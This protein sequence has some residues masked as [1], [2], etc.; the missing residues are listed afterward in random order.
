MIGPDRYNIRVYGICLNAFGQVL[1][2]DERRNGVTMTKFPGGGHHLGEG[3]AETLHREFMEECNTTI[4]IFGHF[5]LNDFPQ[6]SAFNPRE[7][8]ISIYYLVALDGPL[9][10]PVSTQVMDFAPG[11]G[12]RQT[13]RWAEISTLDVAD[14]RFPIDK[15]VV[16]RLQSNLGYLEQLVG[17]GNLADE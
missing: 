17:D 5:Y 12:D 4:K 16:E 11:D 13:F 9:Q 7:Q 8:L 2:T 3:L 10:V 1:L 15:V 6:I 14:F